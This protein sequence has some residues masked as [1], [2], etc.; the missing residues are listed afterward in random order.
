MKFCRRMHVIRDYTLDF[1]EFTSEILKRSEELARV[2]NSHAFLSCRMICANSRRTFMDTKHYHFLHESQSLPRMCLLFAREIEIIYVKVR[3]KKH[4]HSQILQNRPSWKLHSRTRQHSR[5][6]AS[7][8][9]PIIAR[10]IPIDCKRRSR[11]FPPSR[12]LSSI[13]NSKP[14]THKLTSGASLALSY[15]CDT[16]YL[17]VY[18]CVFVG[19]GV[20]VC[21][22]AYAYICTCYM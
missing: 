10:C 1:R 7:R 17:R 4:C 22:C 11:A 18:M 6:T 13:E 19:G 8:I 16:Q 14:N 9:D 2:K 20:C 12:T 3:E 15:F 5:S 21:V